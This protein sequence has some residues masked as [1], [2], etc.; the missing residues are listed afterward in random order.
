LRSLW[1]LVTDCGDAA[2]TLPLALLTLVFLVASRERRLAIVWVLTIGGCAMT[3]GALKLAFA[4][5]GH[6]LTPL[7]I[8]SPSGHTAMSTAVYLSLALLVGAA[9][10]PAVRAALFGGAGLLVAVIAV[11]RL[12]LDM[13]D[14]S[15]V[16]IGLA[17]GLAA[18]GGF[19]ATLRRQPAPAVPAL[20]LGLGALGVVVVMH[21]TRL[22]IEPAVHRLAG[23]FRLVL[24]WCR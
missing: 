12:T 21:G 9:L 3:I 15:E 24:P 23:T 14:M 17:V 16:A 6:P 2:V 1:V 19:G 18:V 5:C 7:E 11:S 10:A 8:E 20:W 4:A 13:H 22:M